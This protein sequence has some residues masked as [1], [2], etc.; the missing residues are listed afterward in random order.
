MLGIIYS[1]KTGPNGTTRGE[2][3]SFLL[4]GRPIVVV[5]G[6]GKYTKGGSKNPVKGLSPSRNTTDILTF[7]NFLTLFFIKKLS[8]IPSDTM[9]VRDTYKKILTI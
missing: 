3:S 5:K 2:K 7:P 4:S 8:T 1:K 6:G 9:S